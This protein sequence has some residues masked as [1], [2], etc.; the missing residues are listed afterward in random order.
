MIDI[1]KEI[2]FYLQVIAIID[3]AILIWLIVTWWNRRF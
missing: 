3:A 1:V 2:V